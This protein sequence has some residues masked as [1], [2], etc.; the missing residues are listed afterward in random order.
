MNDP[1]GASCDFTTKNFKFVLEPHRPKKQFA[2]LRASLGVFLY[3]ALS[4]KHP[5]QRSGQQTPL[6]H[7]PANHSWLTD[8]S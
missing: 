7:F 6:S 1:P 3:N 4:R 5:V 2:A 8:S